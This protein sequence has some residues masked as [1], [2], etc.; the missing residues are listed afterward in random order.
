[1]FGAK[2]G[3]F[4]WTEEFRA[5]IYQ[6]R[7]IPPEEFNVVF[8]HVF[9]FSRDE[10]PEIR[11]IEDTA[12]TPE[13]KVKDAIDV[14]MELDPQILRSPKGPRPKGRDPMPAC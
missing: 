7:T 10:N 8:K 5:F 6:G 9:R 2:R 14:L 11:L 13:Q 12:P 1:V 3:E 4:I